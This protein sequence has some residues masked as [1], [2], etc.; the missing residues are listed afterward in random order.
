[1]PE[2]ELTIL[3]SMVQAPDPGQCTNS[4]VRR[5]GCILLD[6]A[7]QQGDP[8]DHRARQEYDP[9]DRECAAKLQP[10]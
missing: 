2:E 10:A 9:V 7:L 8:S 6:P 5:V 4:R 3:P 1:M